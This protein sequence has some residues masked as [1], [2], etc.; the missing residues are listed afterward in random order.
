[1]ETGTDTTA[2]LLAEL[3]AE[4]LMV[5][6]CGVFHLSSADG[7]ITVAVPGVEDSSDLVRR[8]FIVAVVVELVEQVINIIHVVE[9]IPANDFHFVA[10]SANA[11]VMGSSF[12]IV[13]VRSQDMS[14]F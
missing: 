9:L 3:F 2:E 1:M 4:L 12:E 14:L 5:V 6:V 8:D 7:T 13:C 11:S 10:F